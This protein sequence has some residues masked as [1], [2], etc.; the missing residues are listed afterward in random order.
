[1]KTLRRQMLRIHPAYQRIVFDEQ[2]FLHSDPNAR[3]GIS[4]F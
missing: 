2:Y 3:R 4:T 1:M